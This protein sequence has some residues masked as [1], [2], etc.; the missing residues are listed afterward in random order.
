MNEDPKKLIDR[1]PAVILDFIKNTVENYLQ[2]FASNKKYLNEYKLRYENEKK[3]GENQNDYFVLYYSIEKKLKETKLKK[4]H[5]KFLL[6]VSKAKNEEMEKQ[7][8]LLVSKV[9]I[10]LIYFIYISN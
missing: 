8:K 2:K 5:L 4:K 9:D 10:K 6:H 3:F 7:N 1:D